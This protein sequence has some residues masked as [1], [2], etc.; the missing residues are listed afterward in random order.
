MVEARDLALAQGLV[1]GAF[2]TL[3]ASADFSGIPVEANACNAVDIIS[4]LH[5]MLCI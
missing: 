3:T 4:M 1:D 5:I 2:V